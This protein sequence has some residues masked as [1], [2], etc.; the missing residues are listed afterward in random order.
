MLL[1]YEYMCT[2][3]RACVCVCACTH[4]LRI[5]VFMCCSQTLVVR[6]AVSILHVVF[7]A[8]ADFHCFQCNHQLTDCYN[9]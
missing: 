6:K 5:C 7:T 2:Y 8:P 4:S 9:A 1:V 3:L